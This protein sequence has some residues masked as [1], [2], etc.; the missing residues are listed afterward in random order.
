MQMTKG[1][2]IVVLSGVVC[3]G[4]GK[5]NSLADGASGEKLSE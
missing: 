5:G 4:C 1:I 3:L 2:L